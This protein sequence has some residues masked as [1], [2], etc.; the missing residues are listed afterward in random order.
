MLKK[1]ALTLFACT[2][3]LAACTP[4]QTPSLPEGA[5]P[6]EPSAEESGTQPAESSDSYPPPILLP[7]V[8]SGSTY[9]EPGSG[10][11]GGVG[12]EGGGGK[13]PASG[14][15]MQPGVVYLDSTVLTNSQDDPPHVIL[16]LSGNLP[17]PCHEIAFMIGQPDENNRI[18]V[19][20]YSVSDPGAMCV[21]VLQPFTQEIDLGVMDGGPFTIL[22]N[23]AEVLVSE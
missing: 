3:I 18:D 2:L 7:V 6:Q 4:A 9:P 12:E 8:G 17:T 23:G 20:V 19:N 16:T 5:T 11:G 14:E 15:F 22:V 13:L 21:Q 1:I 10:E